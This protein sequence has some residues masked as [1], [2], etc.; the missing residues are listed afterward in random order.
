MSNSEQLVEECLLRFAIGAASTSVRTRILGDVNKELRARR[1]DG[2]L[3]WTAGA[4]LLIALSGNWIVGRREVAR[5]SRWYPSRFDRS[6]TVDEPTLE[7]TKYV[8]SPSR[9][10]QE[11]LIAAYQPSGLLFRDAVPPEFPATQVAAWIAEIS[12]AEDGT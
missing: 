6:E 4:I 8:D 10:L 7:N 12:D 5:V 1:R 2:R 9:K 11:Y 3:M